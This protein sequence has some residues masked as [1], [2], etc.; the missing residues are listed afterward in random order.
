[1]ANIADLIKEYRDIR[2]D[3]DA[4]RKDYMAFEKESKEKMLGLE[5]Q[6]LAIA[7]D[8]GV[9]SFKTPHGTAYKTIKTYARLSAGSEAKEARIQ[10]A[11]DN[12]DF[13]LF[14][15][16]VNKTH[17]KELLDDGVNLAEA[18]IDW[19]EEYTIGFRKPTN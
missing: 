14:T 15:S 18:G 11:I 19:I 1:M 9:D 17:A 12:N 6:M 2:D 16:H 8:T 3:L 13:G 5:T 4:R 7:N 10:Y